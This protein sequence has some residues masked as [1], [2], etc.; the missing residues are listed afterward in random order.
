[1]H[2]HRI[3]GTKTMVH[4]LSERAHKKERE[5]WIRARHAAQAGPQNAATR[6]GDEKDLRKGAKKGMFAE[7]GVACRLLSLT[8]AAR[9]LSPVAGRS[10]WETTSR[11]DCIWWGT[12]SS[13]SFPCKFFHRS[14]RIV[15]CFFSCQVLDVGLRMVG[16]I[17]PLRPG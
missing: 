11:F 13:R 12:A 9:N 8:F 7:S 10:T 2:I 6:R 15:G 4:L 3:V 17:I 14:S 5:Q 1:M 16:Y